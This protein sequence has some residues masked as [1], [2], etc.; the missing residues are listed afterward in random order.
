[1]LK[2]RKR[3]VLHPLPPTSKRCGNSFSTITALFYRLYEKI[4]VKFPVVRRHCGTERVKVIFRSANQNIASAGSGHCHLINRSRILSSET[5]SYGSFM[6]STVKYA[7]PQQATDKCVPR[8]EG[9]L[10]IRV[11]KW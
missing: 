3:G 2:W 1:M 4:E 10:D 6:K 8:R 5:K 11:F 7:N 9:E